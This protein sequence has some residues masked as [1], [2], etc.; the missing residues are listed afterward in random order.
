[1]AEEQHTA[2]VFTRWQQM[3]RQQQ[4]VAIVIA[5]GIIAFLVLAFNFISR[6]QYAVLYRNLEPAQAQPLVQHLQER[7]VPYNLDDYGTTIK[8]PHDLADEMRI[9]MAGKGGPYA[10]GLGFE[11][12][13]EERLGATDFERQVKLQRALQEELRRTITS[14]DAVEQARVHLALPE[15]RIFMEERGDPS[16][17]VYLHANHL[18]SLKDDQVRGIV[19]LVA[20]SVEDLAPENVTVVDSKGSILYD[21]VNTDDPYITRADSAV[22]HLE[23]KRSFELELE[24]KVQ[25]ML[26]RVFGPGKAMAIVTAELDFDSRETTIVTYNEEGVP[27]SS[28]VVEENFEGEGAVQGEVGEANYPGY[29]GVQ[30][31]GESS[32]ERRE[33]TVNYEVG[34]SS[35]RFISAPGR[36]VN[37]HT[38]VVVDT[39]D[40]P[41]NQEQIV[42][43]NELVASA[44]GYDQ[45][46]GDQINVQAMNFDTSLEEEME[47]AAAQAQAQARQQEML[48]QAVWGG[49]ALAAV[50]LVVVVLKRR[51]RLKYEKKELLA[52]EGASLDELF[53]AQ[54]QE[55]PEVSSEASS[56]GYARKM[57]HKNPEAAASVLKSWMAD[58]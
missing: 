31:G 57:A 38:S 43:V 16:A 19:H 24:N 13:D 4:I 51:S 1:M 45:E 52:T 23:V 54:D 48:R 10:Q 44:I 21:A 29:V 11:L 46:R 28:Q 35:E 14:L 12:F 5:A 6:A 41:I 49:V 32:Y 30:P 37:L 18:V 9:E 39:G 53:G 8:V 50:I 42:Q 34:E 20:S 27:R 47:V 33:E 25:N 15:P 2:S 58:D 40:N 22:K 26:E 7:G 17:A 3:S 36:V 55:A 56:H